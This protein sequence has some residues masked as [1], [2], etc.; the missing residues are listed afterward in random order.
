M[1]AAKV[2]I[3]IPTLNRAHYLELALKSALQQT[4]GNLEIVVSNNASA[5]GTAALLACQTDPRIRVVEQASTLSMVENWNACLRAATGEYFLLL[6][7]DDLL[8]PEAIES[9]VSAFEGAEDIDRVGMVYC[10]GRVIDA[11]GKTLRLGQAGPREECASDLVLGLLRGM[12][13]TWPCSVLF[14]RLDMGDGYS[15]NFLLITDAAM[16]VQAVARHGVALYID[17]VLVSY[18]VHQNLTSKTPSSVWQEDNEKFVSFAIECLEENRR[19]GPDRIAEIRRALSR[20][21]A[22]LAVEMPLG[23]P[24]RTACGVL[25]QYWQQRS[26]LAGFYGAFLLLRVLANSLVPHNLR[27]AVK[28]LRAR[29]ERPS[30]PARHAR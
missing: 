8:E 27:T 9:M 24:D 15:S 18:R 11:E 19:A 22:R 2:T 26:R 10:G 28:K 21:N 23:R 30:A 17:A 25:R 16:W 7:D 29:G 1:N 14:R 5:D 20:L 3:A 6:S 13:D 4:Y 12:R